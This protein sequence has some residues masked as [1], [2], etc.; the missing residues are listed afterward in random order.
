MWVWGFLYIGMVFLSVEC[1]RQGGYGSWT[2][3]TFHFT[4]EGNELFP[5]VLLGTAVISALCVLMAPALFRQLRKQ[6]KPALGKYED[7]GFKRAD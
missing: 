1:M 3:D 4:A 6:P 5:Q 7:L 2:G